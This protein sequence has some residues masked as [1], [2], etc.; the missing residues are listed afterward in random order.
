MSCFVDGFT[1]EDGVSLSESFKVENMLIYCI[2]VKYG[3]YY[4]NMYTYI[5]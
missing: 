4:S 3:I 5:I 2:Q 1:A